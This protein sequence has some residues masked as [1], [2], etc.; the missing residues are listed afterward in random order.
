MALVST[1]VHGIGKIPEL[2]KRIQDGQAPSQLTTQLLQDWGF[3]ST[4]DRAFIP[5]LKALGFLTPDG[6]PTQRYNDYRDHSKSKSI[7]T[8]AIKEAYS[9]IF[10]ITANPT[11]AD[12]DSIDGK[13]KSFHNASDNVAGLMS[14]TF[15]ALKSLADFTAALPKN[16]ETPKKE[17]KKDNPVEVESGVDKAIKKFGPTSLNYN[18]QI[19]LPATKD[20]EVYNAIFKSLKEHLIE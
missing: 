11:D 17:I 14:K 18:I 13:F 8:E 19:H 9:D 2:F 6:K 5:L 10:L 12:R 15:F 16:E 7:M 1:Y 20:S 3:K 4:N